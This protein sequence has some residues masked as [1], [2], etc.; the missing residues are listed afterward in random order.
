MQ[1]RSQVITVVVAMMALFASANAVRLSLDPNQYFFYAPEDRAAWECA[2]GHVA[3]VC[4]V[5]LA[6]AA[7]FWGVL[8][9]PRPVLW[10]R[11]AIGLVVLVPWALLSTMVVVHAPGYVLFHHLWVWL[12][13]GLLAIAAFASAG[14]GA[15]AKVREAMS[16]SATKA[17]R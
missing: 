9:S 13:V 15:F 6:E 8:V 3:F 5:M 2:P 14:W 4:S 7:L 1:R 11:C 10:V 16:G 17:G 12:L